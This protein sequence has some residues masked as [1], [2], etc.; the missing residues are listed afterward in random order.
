MRQVAGF[1]A[2]TA[3][4]VGHLY[5][6]IGDQHQGIGSA[7]LRL[8]QAGSSGSLGLYTFARNRVARR[9]YERHGF[10]AV[11]HGFEPTWRLAD[12]RYEWKLADE[13]CA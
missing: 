10:V 1:I 9:F 6:R 11:A 13:S 5:V 8:A 7:L 12:V 4:S 3:E 2:C